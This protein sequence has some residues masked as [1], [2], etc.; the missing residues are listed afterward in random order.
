MPL[1]VAIH[2]PHY[3]P[4]L[5]YFDKMARADL[6]IA[7]DDVEFTRNGWQNRNRIKTASG[8][9]ILTVPVHQRLGQT[10]LEVEISGGQGWARK[11]LATLRQAYA[12]APHFARLE[13]DLN[14]LLAYPWDRLAELNMAMIT[15]HQGWLGLSVPVIRSSS[16]GLQARGTARLIRLIQ[17]VGGT[18]YL[19]GAHALGEY[20]DPRQFL[21]AG[22]EL[23]VH[24]WSSPPYR[25]AHPK[26]GLLGDLATLDLI[27]AEGPASLD[28]LRSGGRVTRWQ[29]PST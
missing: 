10:I 7:L 18:G 22:L 28:L 1:I 13:A 27:A 11:H 23:W 15:L 4:W 14:E 12:K 26:A 17:A 21:R 8:P 3:L 2:Q 16:L 6:F 25:Q 24:E 20:L 5:R 9:L 19:T 29:E